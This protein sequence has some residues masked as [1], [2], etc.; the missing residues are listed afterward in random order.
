M[1]EK[2]LILPNER[3]LVINNVLSDSARLYPFLQEIGKELALPA[4]ME[5]QLVLA[6]EEALVNSIQY[7]Y[8][9][10]TEGTIVLLA[11]YEADSHQL[12]FTL[13]DQGTPFDPTTVPTVDT[14]LA[15]EDR[16]NGGLGI[17]LIKRI[18]DKV[19]Y[20]Y[21]EGSNCLNLWK[22]IV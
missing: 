14:T 8:P 5:N 2:K 15:L 21:T 3:R 7:A 12:R 20:N 9:K 1:N 4:A 18:M 6:L 13:I 11:N 16:P 19:E 22:R 17:F 10:G